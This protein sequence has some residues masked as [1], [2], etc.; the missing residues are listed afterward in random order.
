MQN[1]PCFIYD[2]QVIKLRTKISDRQ[3]L[4]TDVREREIVFDDTS[5]ELYVKKNSQ[6]LLVKYSESSDSKTT[7][8]NTWSQ[9]KTKKEIIKMQLVLG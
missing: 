8:A 2:H 6:E 7:T 5:N 9:Q 4:P 1:N 3:L